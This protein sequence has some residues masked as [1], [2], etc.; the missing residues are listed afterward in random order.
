MFLDPKKRRQ[1][2]DASF[3]EECCQKVKDG[4]A[5]NVAHVSML[6]IVKRSSAVVV[7]RFNGSGL[8]EFTMILPINLSIS[9]A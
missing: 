1:I 3:E 4:V 5:F 2:G 9:K 8:A 6:G 7:N